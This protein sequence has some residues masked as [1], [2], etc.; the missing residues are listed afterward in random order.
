MTTNPAAIAGLRRQITYEEAHRL[1]NTEGP[2]VTYDYAAIRLVQSPLF[3]RMGEKL[4]AG[5]TDQNMARM[6]EVERRHEVT[7]A[8]MRQVWVT[9]S[10]T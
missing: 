9:R 7:Q 2:P 5:V 6:V 3:Q 4:E 8:A 10:Q 1:A